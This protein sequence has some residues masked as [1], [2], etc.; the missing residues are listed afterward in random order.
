MRLLFI[1]L[2]SFLLSCSD[3]ESLNSKKHL[4]YPVPTEL[5]TLDPASCYDEA[6]N[7]II[8]QMYETLLEYNYK[9]R[10]YRLQPLLAKSLPHVSSDGLIY[11]FKIKKNILYHSGILKN[12]PQ[13]T[14]KAKD[15]ITQI[16][17]I[18]F[19]PTK[20]KGWW[21]FDKKVKGLNQFREKAKTLEDFFNLPVEGLQAP[22]DYTFIIKLTKPDPEF[23]YAFAMSFTTAIPEEIVKEKNNL[24][25]DIVLGT[26]PFFLKKWSYSSYLDLE[27]NP[28]YHQPRLPKIDSIRFSIIKESSTRWL[29]FAKGK[30]DILELDK[31][32]HDL[33][34]NTKGELREEFKKKGVQR[35]LAPSLTYWWTSF[36]MN[37]PL[38]GKNLN[39][40]K[41]IAYAIN[42]DR[43]IDLFT[44]NLGQ[45]SGSIYPP[46]IE[47]HTPNESW[48]IDYDLKKA[49]VYLEK[50]GYPNGRGLPVFNFDL[51][52]ANTKGRQ[53]GEFYQSQLAKI[54]V[55]LEIIPNAF[56][57]F[58]KK[59]RSGQLEI[60]MDGW[61]MDYPD[62]SNSL[63]LL[64]SRNKAPGPN[65][66]SFQNEA[67]D[68][69][70]RELQKTSKNQRE[71]RKKTLNSLQEII[72]KE[73]PW[74]ML[75]YS[76]YNILLQKRVKNYQ[77]SDIVHNFFK[78]LEVD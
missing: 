20:A 29:N 60:W 74:H 17:R 22:D 40:R 68:K 45:K 15:F 10:P 2:L 36:N 26:G 41:A 7:R 11:T 55:R 66:T 78:Y 18:A 3:H 35:V 38:L 14:L 69:L 61:I 4:S 32:D 49:K 50:A 27:K 73:L 6:C 56:P 52:N 39:L 63:Q 77:Y 28:N 23:L 9:K 37:H 51:R 57:S 21:L 47:G 59:A 30:L 62:P 46:G 31:D 5:S 58:L 1:L 16:K 72:K 12:S 44:R 54:G 75:Y 53:M 76:R 43:F 34:F 70:F 67:F 19:A 48:P 8:A 71:K 42:R 65:V 25:R 24:L 33:T 64:F 13:R